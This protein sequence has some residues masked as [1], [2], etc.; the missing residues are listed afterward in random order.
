MS[1]AKEQMVRVAEND[2]STHR[3]E[4]FRAHGF[5]GCLGTDRHKDRGVDRPMRRMQFAET[6][7]GLLA[8]FD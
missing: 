7:T 4:F 8:C 6:C 3:L 2:T 5:Y 1:R